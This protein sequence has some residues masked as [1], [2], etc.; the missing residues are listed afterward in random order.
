M[1]WPGHLSPLPSFMNKPFLYVLLVFS[2][3]DVESFHKFVVNVFAE[4]GRSDKSAE[5]IAYFTK[6]VLDCWLD[7]MFEIEDSVF[8]SFA[9]EIIHFNAK[10][11]QE[12]LS[13]KAKNR[14]KDESS[15][16]VQLL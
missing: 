10:R 13:V 7:K 8:Q 4:C 16:L 9:S 11:F 5:I 1:V 3:G 2:I 14:C 12:E 6:D 15:G